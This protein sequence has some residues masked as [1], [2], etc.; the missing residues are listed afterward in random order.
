MSRDFQA[1]SNRQIQNPAEERKGGRPRRNL[2]ESMMQL[3]TG[4]Q[5][6]EANWT[7]DIDDDNINV[8]MEQGRSSQAGKLQ[9]ALLKQSAPLVH[10]QYLG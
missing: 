7:P 4:G 2:D 8:E 9:Y 10:C 5:N 6:A 3:D 1:N